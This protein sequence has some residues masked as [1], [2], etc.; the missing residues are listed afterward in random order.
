MIHFGKGLCQKE[1]DKQHDPQERIKCGQGQGNDD[2]NKHFYTGEEG[3]ILNSE[4]M[5]LRVD[6]KVSKRVENKHR[7]NCFQ[8]RAADIQ[9]G[10]Q[11][12]HTQIYTCKTRDDGGNNADIEKGQ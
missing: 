10:H 4:N 5:P 9:E 2:G 3:Q 11:Y 8:R 1:G 12:H 6:R 7:H